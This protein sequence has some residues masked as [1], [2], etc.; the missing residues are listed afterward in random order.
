MAKREPCKRC[1]KMSEV[2]MHKIVH[3]RFP[4]LLSYGGGGRGRFCTPDPTASDFTVSFY[5]SLCPS[6]LPWLFILGSPR[7]YTNVTV[8]KF[9]ARRESCKTEPWKIA[10]PAVRSD[11]V[12]CLRAKIIRHLTFH[13]LAIACRWLGSHSC[14]HKS[15]F[16][17]GGDTGR[18]LCLR[19][20]R[21]R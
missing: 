17:L 19:Q 2:D 1:R 14:A 6:G 9:A 11:A 5:D 10:A 18:P 12:V 15:A 16:Q 20:E 21:A 4:P 3:K 13:I 8:V 7:L